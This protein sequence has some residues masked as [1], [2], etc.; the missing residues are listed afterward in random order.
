MM[1]DDRRIASYQPGPVCCDDCP[2]L[3]N[4]SYTQAKGLNPDG[5]A[6]NPSGTVRRQ[7]HKAVCHE[8]EPCA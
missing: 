8:T 6:T 3:G 4:R 7:G 5:Q 1:Q 2:A